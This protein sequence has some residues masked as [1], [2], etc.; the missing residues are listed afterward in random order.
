ML[1]AAS[2]AASS[3]WD[4]HRFGLSEQRLE[5]PLFGNVAHAVGGNRSTNGVVEVLERFVAQVGAVENLPATPVDHL[6]LL[7]HHFV[8]LQDVLAG[9]GVAALDGVLGRSIARVTI[10]AS[11][12]TS[13]GRPDP[14]PSP[15]RRWR[16]NA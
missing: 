13:S 3:I 12:G 16:T 7:V 11:S 6:A 2:N 14:S 15:W 8:V 10:F 4:G 1:E 5:I 9:L